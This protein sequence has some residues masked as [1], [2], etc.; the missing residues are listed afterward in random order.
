[1]KVHRSTTR[2]FR[3]GKPPF[4]RLWA[5]PVVLVILGF[6]GCASYTLVA[7]SA[8]NPKMEPELIRSS[9]LDGSLSHYKS[10]IIV[11]PDQFLDTSPAEAEGQGESVVLLQERAGVWIAEFERA[12]VEKG[13][14]VLSRSVLDRRSVNGE[15]QDILAAAGSHDADFLVQINA[16]EF[17]HDAPIGEGA[18]LDVEFFK[19]NGRGERRGPVPLEE[20]EVESFTDW[21]VERARM[22]LSLRYATYLDCQ[23]VDVE[24]GTVVLFYKQRMGHSGLPRSP[25]VEYLLYRGFAGTWQAVEP[26]TDVRESRDFG[27]PPALPPVAT[28][29][30][31]TGEDPESVLMNMVRS[32]TRD[33]VETISNPPN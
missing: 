11:P 14:R 20:E 8:Q 29:V 22:D 12:F 15:R 32:I 19:S 23:I 21:A 16:L 17:L 10:V 18:V 33:L 30:R 13:Y 31:V 28:P 4:I 9:A 1:M 6:S 27:E 25:M 2:S 7:V 5:I 3:P 26:L 24:T